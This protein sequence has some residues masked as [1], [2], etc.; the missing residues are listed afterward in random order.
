MV[1]PYS[2]LKRADTACYRETGWT[3]G[4]PN[5]PIICELAVTAMAHGKEDEEHDGPSRM[6]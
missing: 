4:L 2:F 3:G 1:I 5:S 6:V